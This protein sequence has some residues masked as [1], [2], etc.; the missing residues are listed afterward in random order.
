MRPTRPRGWR[1]RRKISGCLLFLRYT[2]SI[3]Q[4]P[5]SPR[6]SSARA[7]AAMIRIPVAIHAALPGRLDTN[8][9]KLTEGQRSGPREVAR[10][11]PC[12][13]L[14]IEV[15]AHP[16]RVHGLEHPFAKGGGGLGLAVEREPIR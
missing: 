16:A 8:P 5:A 13:G 3:S 4:W 2:R 6:T 12:A 10:A 9:G 15:L 7:M 11:Q 14:G 1:L